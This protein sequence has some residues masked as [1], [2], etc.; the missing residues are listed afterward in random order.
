MLNKLLYTLIGT[1]VFAAAIGCSDSNSNDDTFLDKTPFINFT[2]ITSFPHDTTLF[3]EGLLIHNGKFFESSGA[4]TECPKCK[5]VVGVTN[6]STGTFEKKIE[7]DKSTYFGEGI[8]F[9]GNKLYQ[10]TYKNQIG[11]IYDETSFKKIDSFRY[12]NKEGWSLTSNRKTLIMSDGSNNLTFLDPRNLKVLK[13]LQVTENGIARDSLNEL[14]YIKGFIYAN[15]WM[16]NN[17]VK[18]D[19]GSGKVIGKIDLTGLT[20]DA[21]RRNPNGDV[22]NGI[23]YDSTN[24]K[25][26]VTGKMWSRIYQ[27]DF[28][29]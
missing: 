6:L 7:L 17:I 25:I 12:S 13:V 2:V 4:P 5:S 9:F 21:L 15:I 14:E 11:F 16:N 29:H 28:T 23:A 20:N 27:I 10:L 18:I 1:I 24:D 19:T 22:L 8:A 26:Y 3:T